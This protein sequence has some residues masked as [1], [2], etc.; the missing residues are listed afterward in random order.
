MLLAVACRVGWLVGYEAKKF[1]WDVLLVLLAVAC[2]AGWSVRCE[3]GK[4]VQV[5]VLLVLVWGGAISL[6]DCLHLCVC[7][8]THTHM[9]VRTC[10]HA[11]AHT[12]THTHTG[13]ASTRHPPFALW[14]QQRTC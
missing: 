4:E 2:R 8:R 12:H 5:G 13:W 11:R 6:A 7:A 3:A 1:R 10:M 14:Q 9:H